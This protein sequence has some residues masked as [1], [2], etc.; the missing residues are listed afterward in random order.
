M[1]SRW[2]GVQPA[3]PAVLQEGLAAKELVS[4]RPGRGKTLSLYTSDLGRFLLPSV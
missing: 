1:W 4:S 2:Q 3:E